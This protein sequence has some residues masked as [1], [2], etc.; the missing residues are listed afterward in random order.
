MSPLAWLVFVRQVNNLISQTPN[1]QFDIKSDTA[2]T[3]Q[4]NTYID[5]DTRITRGDGGSGE[6]TAMVTI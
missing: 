4:L 1:L 2:Q 5:E 3:W 6:M